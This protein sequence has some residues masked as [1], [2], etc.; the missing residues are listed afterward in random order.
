MTL[1]PPNFTPGGSGVWAA[2]T[3]TPGLTWAN[4][5]QTGTAMTITDPGNGRLQVSWS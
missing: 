2:G 4:G 3:Q 1:G 5:D